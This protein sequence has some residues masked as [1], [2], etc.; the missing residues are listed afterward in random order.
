MSAQLDQEAVATDGRRRTLLVGLLFLLPAF[1]LLGALVV[2]PIFFS[3]VRSMFDQA[4]NTFVGTRNYR[5]IFESEATRTAIKNTLIWVVF[6]PS[7]V[8]ALG[9]VFAVL[10]ERIRCS[11]AFKVVIFMPMAVSFLSAGVTWRLIYEEDPQLGLANAAAREVADVVRPPGVV[12]GAHPSDEESLRPEG[13]GY[14]TSG[15]F[16]PGDTATLGLVA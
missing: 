9:L 8:T 1:V 15:T 6:A 7:I 14:I 4:G 5:T 2:Y 13:Q 16:A 3:V 12:P 10:S 11:T